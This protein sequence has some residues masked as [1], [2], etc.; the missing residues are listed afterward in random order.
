MPFYPYTLGSDQPAAPGTPV[1][2][3]G[4]YMRRKA[5]WLAVAMIVLVLWPIS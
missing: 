1:L 3:G 2:G 4:G 5:W